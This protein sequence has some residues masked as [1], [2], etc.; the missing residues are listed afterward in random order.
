[1]TYCVA[2]Y[3]PY[4]AKPF[5][6]RASTGTACVASSANQTVKHGVSRYNAIHNAL[7][8]L[9]NRSTSYI[10]ATLL[11]DKEFLFAQVHYR[12]LQL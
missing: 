6:S 7:H 11:D 4:I 3:I 8:A 5:V 12:F 1:M 9:H 10:N 2:W